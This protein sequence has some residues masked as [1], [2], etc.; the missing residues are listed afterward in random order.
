MV[1]DLTNLLIESVDAGILRKQ[2]G[3]HL[4]E[5]FLLLGSDVFTGFGVAAIAGS[6]NFAFGA[7]HIN[8]RNDNRAALRVLE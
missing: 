3:A 6:F 8:D 1:F 7:N 4:L 2:A 5:A